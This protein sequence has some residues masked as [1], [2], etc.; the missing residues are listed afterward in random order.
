[1][2]VL[3]ILS[4]EENCSK[5]FR[6]TRM[7]RRPT[8]PQMRFNTLKRGMET[9]GKGLKRQQVQNMWKNIQ[10]QGLEPYSSIPG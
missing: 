6:E 10:R 2:K 7:E 1:M 8:L 4:S 3:D 5:L 9:T